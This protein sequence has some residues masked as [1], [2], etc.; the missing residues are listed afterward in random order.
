[1]ISKINLLECDSTTYVVKRGCFSLSS[2][3]IIK[4]WVELGGKKARSVNWTEKL[5]A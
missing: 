1:M 3:K 5:R 2:F 4:A